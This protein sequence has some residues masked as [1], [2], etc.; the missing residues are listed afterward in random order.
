MDKRDLLSILS[1]LKTTADKRETPG[2]TTLFE[3]GYSSAIMHLFEYIEEFDPV[4][5][6]ELEYYLYCVNYRGISPEEFAKALD[7]LRG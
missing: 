6:E 2:N 7:I 5:Y 3:A 1:S 4:F